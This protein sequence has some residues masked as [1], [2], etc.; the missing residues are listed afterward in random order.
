MKE[1]ISF[2]PIFIYVAYIITI[3]VR[4]RRIRRDLPSFIEPKRTLGPLSLAFSYWAT[5][6]SCWWALG[7]AGLAYTVGIQS[8]WF[9]AGEVFFAIIAWYI[10]AP[11]FARRCESLQARSIGD[12]LTKY[13]TDNNHTVKM[14]ILAILFCI[15]PLYLSAQFAGLSRVTEYFFYERS[16]LLFVGFSVL[17]LMYVMIGGFQIVTK[18]S[19]LHGILMFSS[20]T[21]VLCFTLYSLI[22][23]YSAI[24][25]GIFNNASYWSI[26]GKYGA[27]T[28]GYLKAFSEFIVG[29]GFL[30][31]PNLLMK[32]LNGRSAESIKKAAPYGV[33]LFL[34]G[35][36]FI[37]ILG[38]SA[39]LLVPDMPDGEMTLSMLS[40]LFLPPV[41]K[42]LIFLGVIAAIFSTADSLLI[43]LPSW[44]IHDVYNKVSSKK[45]SD[46][47]SII[48]AQTVMLFAAL[49][50]YLISQSDS[51]LIFWMVNFVWV[52]IS[53]T[54]APLI[55]TSLFNIKLSSAAAIS[56]IFSGLLVATIWNM[57]FYDTTGAS[58]CG[59][60][61]IASFSSIVLLGYRGTNHEDAL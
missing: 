53:C 7:L 8:I 33:L 28:K 44:L 29:I 31:A 43:L 18:L 12:Y 20:V 54:F 3:A 21:L 35:D 34:L 1:L 15:I 56:S 47:K 49:I 50:G 6:E 41:F 59:P 30:G 5:G 36:L 39:R 26:W 25:Q 52:A 60:G 9:F 42:G 61:L 51:R 27:S 45:H 48:C 14:S 40:G 17:L 2:A 32:F 16:G 55:V 19:I 23:N 37:I 24:N 58:G 10:L 57:F 13:C 22:N 11:I 46:D 4:H 38:I